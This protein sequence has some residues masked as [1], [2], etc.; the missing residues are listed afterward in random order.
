MS[1]HKTE[2]Y[3]I[4]DMQELS[5]HDRGRESTGGNLVFSELPTLKKSIVKKY[6]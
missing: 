2:N 4:I 5:W 3:R 1:L 6:D